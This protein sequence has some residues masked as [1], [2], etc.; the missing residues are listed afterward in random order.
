MP[1]GPWHR[2]SSCVQAI[3]LFWL[4]RPRQ[5]RHGCWG[6]VLELLSGIQRLILTRRQ[7]LVGYCEP[8]RIVICPVT[9][10]PGLRGFL[11]LTR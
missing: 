2:Q 4:L 1:I 7:S 8:V 3:T 10:A 6:A 9:N 5:T 11:V